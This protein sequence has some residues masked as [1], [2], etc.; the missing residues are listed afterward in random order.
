MKIQKI[1]VPT[2]FS[3]LSREATQAGIDL[4]KNFGA[5][6]FFLFVIP[7]LDFLDERLPLHE[8]YQDMIR[9]K[10]EVDLDEMIRRAKLEGLLRVHSLIRLGVPHV[11]ILK[12]AK[13]LEIDLIVMGT[14]G[15]SGLN[16]LMLGSQAEQ[17]IR[18]APCAV[19]T[20]RGSI[21]P[22]R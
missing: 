22:T 11:E 2:D 20:V 17:V 14:H 18:A 1:L 21:S 7:P 19:L 15:R 10:A 12:E 3:D 6:L 13:T 16:R 9:D 4:A 5:E 8:E